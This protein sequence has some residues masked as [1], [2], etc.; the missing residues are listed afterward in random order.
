MRQEIIHLLDKTQQ[1]SQSETESTLTK[2]H[3]HSVE[4]SS[5]LIVGRGDCLI[6]FWLAVE[7][8]KQIHFTEFVNLVLRLHNTRQNQNKNESTARTVVFSRD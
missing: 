7:T 1:K 3:R 6:L 8:N 4:T 5:S 2:E